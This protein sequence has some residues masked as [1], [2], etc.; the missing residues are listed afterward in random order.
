MLFIALSYPS[1]LR[2]FL[3]LVT[4]VD[5]LRLDTKVGIFVLSEFRFFAKVISIADLFD[6]Q[7]VSDILSERVI[8]WLN[9]IE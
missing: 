9:R 7:S 6:S 5:C 4:F 1:L 3:I 2:S 8:L